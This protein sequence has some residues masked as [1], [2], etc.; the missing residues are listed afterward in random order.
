MISWYV[1]SIIGIQSGGCNYS[2]SL[3]LE[4]IALLRWGWQVGG[5]GE[6]LW[7]WGESDA[8]KC[9]WVVWV[10]GGVLRE[11]EWIESLFV[12]QTQVNSLIH[13]Y[14]GLT[15]SSP[16]LNHCIQQTTSLQHTA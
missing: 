8:V 10:K 9:G 3:P 11:S 16:H 5:I 1:L 7:E 6:Y 12:Q 14:S 2:P 13:K 15:V 4:E